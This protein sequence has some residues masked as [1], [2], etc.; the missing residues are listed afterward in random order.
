MIELK[1]IENKLLQFGYSIMQDLSSLLQ[2]K[3][4]HIKHPIKYAHKNQ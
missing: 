4:F 1:S 2:I 3:E